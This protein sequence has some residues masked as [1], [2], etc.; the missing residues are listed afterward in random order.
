VVAIACFIA[1][2]IAYCDR[3]NVAVAARQIVQQRHWNTGQM[4][5]VPPGFFLGY[6]VFLIPSGMLVQ[7]VGA[8]RILCCSVAGWSLLTALTPI[9]QTL[10]GMCVVRLLLGIFESANFPA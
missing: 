6:A 8:Y 3:V 4:S 10:A 7:R 5:W 1:L 9:P 2:L